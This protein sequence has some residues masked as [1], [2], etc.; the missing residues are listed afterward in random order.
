MTTTTGKGRERNRNG[1]MRENRKKQRNHN[2]NNSHSHIDRNSERRIKF[3][4]SPIDGT[5][6][7]FGFPW[8]YIVL[9]HFITI[10]YHC[11]HWRRALSCYPQINSDTHTHA[12]QGTH[13]TIG[14]NFFC[15]RCRFFPL[16][17]LRI[18]LI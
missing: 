16:Y 3:S 7:I 13:T 15:R 8:K 12:P 17:S 9:V 10:S 1:N 14:Y 11:L 5:L 6:S 2:N 18:G 4:L